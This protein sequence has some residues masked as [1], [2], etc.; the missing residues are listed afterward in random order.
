MAPGSDP[1]DELT[2]PPDDN[3]LVDLMTEA[4]G[5]SFQEAEPGIEWETVAGVP[6][7]FAGKSLML[8]LKQG[9]RDKDKIDRNFLES[10]D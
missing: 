5:V 3:D 9:Q 10:I 7:P 2:R 8:Q 6:I 4:C 1:E